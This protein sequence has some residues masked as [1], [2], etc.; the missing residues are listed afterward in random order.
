MKALHSIIGPDFRGGSRVL[1]KA[2]VMRLTVS[3]TKAWIRTV[4]AKPILG[5]SCW[6][7]TGKTRPPVAVPEAPMPMAKERRLLK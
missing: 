5:S 4:H 7:I 1:K 2:R 3:M 6:T